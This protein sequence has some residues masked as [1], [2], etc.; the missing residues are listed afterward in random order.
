MSR[1]PGILLLPLLLAACPATIR[2]GDPVARD[3][4][5]CR[6]ILWRFHHDPRFEEVGVTCLDGVVTLKGRV[7]S[8]EARSEA[9]QACFDTRSVRAVVN[10]VEVRPK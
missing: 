3:Q 8:R 7:S 9:E 4:E 1:S 6:D 5:I 10:R 2:S